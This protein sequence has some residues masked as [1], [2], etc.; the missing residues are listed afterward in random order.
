MLSALYQSFGYT[1]GK[2][3]N[4][5]TVEE[6]EDSDDDAAQDGR[7]DFAVA[8]ASA[9]NAASSKAVSSSDCDRACVGA[10]SAESTSATVASSAAA[11]VGR[12]WI[13]TQ[14]AFAALG[15]KLSSVGKNAQRSV[16]VAKMSASVASTLTK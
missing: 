13:A 8:R 3:E 2:G 5:K 6:F 16:A 4:K 11:A 10:A 1:G 9:A 14:G 12:S 7:R 15:S